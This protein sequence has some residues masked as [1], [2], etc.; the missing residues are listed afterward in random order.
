MLKL[1]ELPL[2]L[3]FPFQVPVELPLHQQEHGRYN[4][5]QARFRSIIS[6][7]YLLINLSFY[8]EMDDKNSING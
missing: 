1:D 4:L 5:E 2:E 3:P 8:V 7:Q 6:I